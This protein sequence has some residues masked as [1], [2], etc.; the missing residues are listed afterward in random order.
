MADYHMCDQPTSL[1]K[2]PKSVNAAVLQNRAVQ[3]RDILSTFSRN[4]FPSEHVPIKSLWSNRIFSTNQKQSK[5]CI[6]KGR[7]GICRPY[8]QQ[9]RCGAPAAGQCS[10]PSL[11]RASPDLWPRG[12]EIS[13]CHTI[14]HCRTIL[15]YTVLYLD[16]APRRRYCRLFTLLYRPRQPPRAPDPDTESDF[17]SIFN[18]QRASQRSSQRSSQLPDTLTLIHRLICS[19]IRCKTKRY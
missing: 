15:Y 10:C 7:P 1:Y 12:A 9:R 2:E 16:L 13:F 18:F 6:K 19:S 11:S 17:N 5:D 3:I 14:D 8:V 4:N